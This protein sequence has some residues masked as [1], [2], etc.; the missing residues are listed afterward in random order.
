MIISTANGTDASANTA[1]TTDTDTGELSLI[2][3]EAQFRNLTLG[4]L[5][6]EAASLAELIEATPN[7]QLLNQIQTWIADATDAKV[8]G[9]CFAA[10]QIESDIETWKLKKEHL[11]KTC[12]RIIERKLSELNSMKRG[13]IQL[14]KLGLISNYLV[15]KIRVIEIRNNSR[16]KVTL[17]LPP[18]DPLFPER[19]RETRTRTVA[20]TEEIAA[21]HSSGQDV[22][23]IADVTIGKQVRFKLRPKRIKKR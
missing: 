2:E 22:S 7:D 21:A 4:E 9:Y 11:M 19:F 3:L 13:L 8:D 16:P 6:F 14:E 18:D 15:G 17:K 12:D 20:L 10:D 1:T 23:A 5:C